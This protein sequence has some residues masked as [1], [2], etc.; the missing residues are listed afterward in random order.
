MTIKQALNRG[1]ILLKNKK[2][3][4][5]GLDA[6]IILSFVLKKPREFLFAHPE[7]LLTPAQYRWFERLIGKRSEFVPLAYIT[8]KKEFFGLTF[9][10]NKNVL[11]PRPE[12]EL[13]VEESIRLIQK[14]EIK[15]IAEIGT[16][17]GCV[18]ISLAKNLKE[19]ALDFFA[20]DISKDALQIAKKNS[21]HH[22]VKSQIN[23][24]R[25]NLALPVR[26]KKIDLLLA[27]LPYLDPAK[28]TDFESADVKS[29]KHE[30][31]IALYGGTDGLESYEELFRQIKKFEYSPSHILIEIGDNQAIPIKKIIGC[32]LPKAKIEIL[33]DLAGRDRV[34][35]II[36]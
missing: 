13:L 9:F 3:F 21:E 10:V 22:T 27:N 24:L 14:K 31:K 30:P 33:K 19:K 4:P 2:I 35:K 6:E 7:K 18:I 1:T 15:N 36:I 17:S 29:L 34:V 23:F 12:T 16:G 25:G 28:K 26:K 20:V 5:A 32:H 11:I 8:G